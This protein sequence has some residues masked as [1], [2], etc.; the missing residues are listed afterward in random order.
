MIVI[1]LIM[2][3]T[4]KICCHFLFFIATLLIIVASEGAALHF[5]DRITTVT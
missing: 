1:Y 4:V 2:F 5:R 3:N